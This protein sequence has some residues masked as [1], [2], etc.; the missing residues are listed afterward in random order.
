MKILEI[1]EIDLFKQTDVDGLVEG[2]TDQECKKVVVTFLATMEI[3]K[4][5]LQIGA[6]FIISHEGIYYS[7]DNKKFLET[8]KLAQA[9]QDYIKKH[10]LCKYNF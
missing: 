2:N 4:K 7:H 5:S 1:L 6:N 9:K 3:L 10:N 8:S